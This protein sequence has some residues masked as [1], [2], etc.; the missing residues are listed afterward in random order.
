M[1][2]RA[3]RKMCFIG[4][5]LLVVAASPLSMLR[6]QTSAPQPSTAAPVAV[7]PAVAPL[8]FE[9][10][11]VKQNKS[12]TSGSHS[13]FRDGRFLASNTTLK[14]LLQCSAYGIPGSRILGGPP[15]I[16]SQG[17]DIEA[18]IDSASL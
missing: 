3:G 5:L 6:A 16:G 2:Q 4:K 7:G 14:N 13:D 15:W 9:V 11:T 1:I 12:G 8:V 10:S 17:F 18:K